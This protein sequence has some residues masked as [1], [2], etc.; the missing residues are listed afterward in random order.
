VNNDKL[1]ATMRDRRAIH[2]LTGAPIL[3]TATFAVAAGANVA[4]LV[5]VLACVLV[6]TMARVRGSARRTDR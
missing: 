1:G 6:I 4:L 5:L 2:V 3:V